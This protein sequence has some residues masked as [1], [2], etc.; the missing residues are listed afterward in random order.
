MVLL[1]QDLGRALVYTPDVRSTQPTA[2]LYDKHANPVERAK[3]IFRKQVQL[4]GRQRSEASWQQDTS[5][6]YV[7]GVLNEN[8][9][10]V[11]QS[12][13]DTKGGK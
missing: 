12:S 1:L 2:E 7:F 11:A 6:F 13:K 8:H 10:C 4:W 5:S 3:G 9:M